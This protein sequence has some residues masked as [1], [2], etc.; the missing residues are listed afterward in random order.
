M[1]K[2]KRAQSSFT[3][4]GKRYYARGK[5]KREADRKADKMLA[6]LKAG[7]IAESYKTFDAW[8]P[9]YLE[10]YKSNV[11]KRTMDDYKSF[12]ET[13]VRPFFRG[14]A[15]KDIK[16][17][18]CQTVL[19]ALEGK[20]KSY[21]NK[22]CFLLN[23]AFEAAV[24]NRLINHNPMKGATRPT[25]TEKKRRALTE[26]ER[27]LFLEAASGCGPAGDYLKLIYYTGLRP[28]EAARVRGEDFNKE[29]RRLKVRGTKTNNAA[30]TVPVPDILPIPSQKGLVF[31]TRN[32]SVIDREG[33]K[34]WWNKVKRK[35]NALSDD[36]VSDDLTLYC[37]RH[38]YGTRCIE[39]G[40][41]IETVSKLMGHSSV[42]LTSRIYLHESEAGINSALEKL[43]SM[44]SGV[45]KGV[46]AGRKAIANKA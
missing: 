18:D 40:I 7:K 37:L 24:N 32:G 22:V 19:N 23:G 2:T 45:D 1:P 9:E 29:K 5:D 44:Y 26:D 6:D 38:D 30:R 31:R 11:S 36:P 10:A 41:N 46:D 42:A 33:E 28:S 15:I 34:R 8:F 17:I 25:G 16:Q 27:K 14:K 43:N 39:A 12:Y 3:F 13:S 4:E 20:S 21:I 35:M